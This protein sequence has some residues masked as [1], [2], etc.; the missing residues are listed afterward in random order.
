MCDVIK[1]HRNVKL[2][3]TAH[4]LCRTM[5]GRMGGLQCWSG[6]GSKDKNIRAIK[7]TKC[8]KPRRLYDLDFQLWQ[9]LA[10]SLTPRSAVTSI[11][12]RR[13]EFAQ[14]MTEHVSPKL[15][16]CLIVKIKAVCSSEN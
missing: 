13:I 10:H 5:H 7:V 12:V 6:H 2:H 1:T 3:T 11:T 15:K 16:K 9:H 8:I 4:Y 14:T